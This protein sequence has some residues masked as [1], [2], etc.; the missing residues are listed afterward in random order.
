M[1]LGLQLLYLVPF[2]AELM[3]PSREDKLS[4]LRSLPALPAAAPSHTSDSRYTQ[5]YTVTVPIHIILS[6]IFSYF[7]YA[8]PSA[9][10]IISPHLV[11]SCFSFKTS[12][13][14]I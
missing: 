14:I 2:S 12:S 13:G 6:L 10:N 4:M 11:Y 7:G 1:S 9:W 3:F 8:V 5:R